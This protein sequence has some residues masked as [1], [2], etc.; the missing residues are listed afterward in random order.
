MP[1]LLLS[2]IRRQSL[3]PLH[4]ISASAIGTGT[5]STEQPDQVAVP[6]GESQRGRDHIES[7]VPGLPAFLLRGNHGT[8]AGFHVV[9]RRARYVL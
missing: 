9:E 8:A 4:K 5:E 6:L 3:S 1:V 7:D 2:R